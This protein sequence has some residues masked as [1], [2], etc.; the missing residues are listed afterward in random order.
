MNR[1]KPLLIYVMGS[2]PATGV[3]YE[4]KLKVSGGYETHSG[5]ND[6]L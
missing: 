5:H 4:N 1:L 3:N 6:S 2:N